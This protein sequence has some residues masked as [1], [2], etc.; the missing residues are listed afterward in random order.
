ME[1]VFA[2]LLIAVIFA[3]IILVYLKRRPKSE[4]KEDEYIPEAFRNSNLQTNKAP[5]TL[6]VNNGELEQLRRQLNTIVMHNKRVFENNV[7]IARRDFIKRGIQ[8]P[9]ETALLKRAI[10]IWQDDNR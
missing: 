5:K 8:N 3:L 9:S 1:Y 2:S 10:E 4:T 7:E 6:P